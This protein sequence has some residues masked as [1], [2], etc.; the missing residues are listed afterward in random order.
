MGIENREP[1][2]GITKTSLKSDI[3]YTVWDDITR[4][5]GSKKYFSIHL[6]KPEIT[7]E[8]KEALRKKTRDNIIKNCPP[9]D[10]YMDFL[11]EVNY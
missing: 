7:E 6:P 1:I 11:E 10:T 3:K 4:A 2:E 5:M 8:E 9:D